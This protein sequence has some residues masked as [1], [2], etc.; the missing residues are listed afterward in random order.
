MI[1]TA[2]YI[3]EIL[4]VLQCIHCV[5]GEKQKIN[6]IYIFTVL[7]L[8]ITLEITN[9]YSAGLEGTFTMYC[10]LA[11]YCILSFKRNARELI[12]CTATYMILVTVVQLSFGVAISLMYNGDRL[13][14]TLI[15]DICVLMFI[16]GILPYLEIPKI[17]SGLFKRNGILLLAVGYIFLIICS[18]LFRVKTD[19]N[20]GVR[21]G[22]YLSIFPLI[23]CVYFVSSLLC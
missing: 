13:I 5:F 15:A 7:S 22:F 6:K 12:I 2:I 3:I 16:A 9:R 1:K 19:N 18:L 11:I 8:W 17:I 10:I 4:S 14:S 21:A 20:L 23:I